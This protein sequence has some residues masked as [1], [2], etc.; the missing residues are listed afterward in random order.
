MPINCYICSTDLLIRQLHDSKLFEFWRDHLGEPED[1]SEMMPVVSPDNVC[2][3]VCT[4]IIICLP[5]SDNALKEIISKGHTL[6][7]KDCQVI[8]WLS[9]RQDINPKA[10]G[11]FIELPHKEVGNLFDYKSTH[12]VPGRFELP[13]EELLKYYMRVN[14]QNFPMFHKHNQNF[15]SLSTEDV[16]KFCQWILQVREDPNYA[17]DL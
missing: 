13:A 4:S 7:F 1:R 3:S 9:S 12:C 10:H 16:D 15:I 14:N 11:N 8:Q 5:Q 17:F 2:A 6:L